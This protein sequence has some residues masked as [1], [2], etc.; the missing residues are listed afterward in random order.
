MDW[1]KFK[2]GV[3]IVVCI[4]FAFMFFYLCGMWFINKNTDKATGV[5]FSAGHEVKLSDWE[6]VYWWVGYLIVATSAAGYGTW[7]YG[8]LDDRPAFKPI[9]KAIETITESNESDESN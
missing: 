8:N 6:S 7:L 5:F 9:S 2:I 3:C 1:D 4:I